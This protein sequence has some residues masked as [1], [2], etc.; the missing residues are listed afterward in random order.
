M[1]EPEAPLSFRSQ[2]ALIRTLHGLAQAGSQF[3]VATHSPVLLS[4][5][6]AVIYEFGDDGVC[7][8]SWEQLDVVQHVRG[9]LEA[10]ERY[11]RHI[12]E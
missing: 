4:I 2:L 12:F 9:F 7:R 10:P 11:L 3:V 6:D 8:S 5:P 1:D